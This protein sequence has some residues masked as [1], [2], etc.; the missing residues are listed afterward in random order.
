MK[1][2]RLQAVIVAVVARAGQ[3]PETL[4]V[5]LSDQIA[6]PRGWAN[7]FTFSLLHPLATWPWTQIQPWEVQGRQEK[8]ELI[9]FWLED[10]EKYIKEP[11]HGS[12]MTGKGAQ[13]NN[14]I[15]SL[16]NLWAHLQAAHDLNFN[17]LPTPW[18]MNYKLAKG[19]GIRSQVQLSQ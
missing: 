7:H 3:V 6:H 12:G 15:K 1:H 9:L 5:I 14:S 13:E 10:W 8:L 16:K 11:E 17:K 4:R 19:W 18:E 2:Q